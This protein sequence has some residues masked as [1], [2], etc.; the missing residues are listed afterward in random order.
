MSERKKK[1]FLLLSLAFPFTVKIVY[2]NL[3]KILVNIEY[4]VP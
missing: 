1:V 2:L 3:S 4:K